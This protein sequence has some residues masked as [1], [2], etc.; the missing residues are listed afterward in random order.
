MRVNL[1]LPLFFRYITLSAPFF[2]LL[3]RLVSQPLQ[4][5][6]QASAHLFIP[7]SAFNSSSCTW[8]SPQQVGPFANATIVATTAFD[9][10]KK[11]KE[12]KNKLKAC[13][14]H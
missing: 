11:K 1:S 8:Y 7:T 10:K 2:F 9:K 14:E 12:K 5:S 4:A 3:F 6:S 13:I